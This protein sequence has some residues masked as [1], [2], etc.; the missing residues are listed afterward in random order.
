MAKV[1]I[2]G[3]SSEATITTAV[4]GIGNRLL[5][6]GA[7]G[8][9]PKV[10]TFSYT[11]NT[12]GTVAAGTYLQLATVGPGWILP[13]SVVSVSAL[14]ASRILNLGTQEYVDKDGTT[15]ATAITALSTGIDVSAAVNCKL[16]GS[17]ATSG[18]YGT[19]F[20]L[21]GRT[22]ILAQVTGGTIPNG[23]TIKGLLKVIEV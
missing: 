7:R 12:G 23:A 9:Q 18:T 6:M 5:G 10:Y 20:Y 22:D 3:K 14:G 4:G 17:D 21:N 2:T 15:Q 8:A 11:N 19:G 13:D 1:A 16:L